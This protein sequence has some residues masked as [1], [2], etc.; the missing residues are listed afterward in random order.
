MS[1][2]T[3]IS[4]KLPI[5]GHMLR[6]AR[7]W[8]ARSVEEAAK[9]LNTSPDNVRKWEAGEA[10]PSVRQARMLAD[11]Y[12]R[13]FLE[14]FL[15]EPPPLRAAETIPDFRLYR[16]QPDPKADR[17]IRVIQEWAE[18]QRLSALDLYDEI[19]EEPG[20]IADDLFATTNDDPEIIAG[21]ARKLSGFAI[22][23][24][25]GLTSQTRSDMPKLV[26]QALEALGVLVL[27][28]SA[29]L[30]LGVRGLCIFAV[31]LPIVVFGAE[32][33]G[34]QSFTMAHELGHV[35]LRQSAISGPPT[36]RDEGSREKAVERWC[37]RFA[38][39]FLV[40]AN[41]VGEIWSKPNRP[42]PAIGDDL[43]G[44]LANK[45]AI[46]RHAMLIRLVHMGYVNAD[47]YW[48]VKRPDFL[49]EEAEYKSAGRAKY[50]GSRYRSSHG[51]LYTG[52][53]LDAWATGKITNH[54]AAQY[55]GVKNLRHLYDIR[56][57]F[58]S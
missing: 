21:R 42:E 9:R 2:G 1:G 43:L 22:E 19:G 15:P 52:L 46:S 31:P 48:N 38:A 53:V 25:F 49:Q 34:A 6:W 32:A 7:E 40:P 18:S 55:M 17:E 14:F 58:G 28:E 27:K 29:L 41:A 54:A 16:G 37:D 3:S 23:A 24:Q 11:F 4:Q 44:Q 56:A 5:N 35:A 47:F 12:D 51:D 36:A 8:R 50:Y 57:D 45:F 10:T 26:R 39:A 20:R 13:A 30:K 33:P